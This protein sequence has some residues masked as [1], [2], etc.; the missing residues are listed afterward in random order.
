MSVCATPHPIPTTVTDN[1][2]ALRQRS[3]VPT[4]AHVTDPHTHST[5]G[6]RVV[7]VAERVFVTVRLVLPVVVT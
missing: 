7:T 4:P 6:Q 3:Y 2:Q 5:L 1:A